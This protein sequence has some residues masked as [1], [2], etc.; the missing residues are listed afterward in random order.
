MA[1]YSADSNQEEVITAD[2]TD[3]SRTGF[4]LSDIGLANRVEETRQASISYEETVT[5]D[6][7]NI[8]SRDGRTFLDESPTPWPI[9]SRGTGIANQTRVTRPGATT[10]FK[11]AV[12]AGYVPTS[13]FTRIEGTVRDTAG[14]IIPDAKWIVFPGPLDIAGSIS[15]NGRFS[16]NLLKQEYGPAFIIVETSD[17][18]FDFR[19]FNDPKVVF[20]V[21]QQ[22]G[23]DLDL[24]FKPGEP[25]VEGGGLFVG[26][27][28]VVGG[29]G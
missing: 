15:S 29:F 20:S 24:Q 3:T 1:T 21:P 8:D 13:D 6:A 5:L 19:W 25:T 27:G 10:D 23:S 14:N 9:E 12:R 2:S 4:S 7:V 17:A 26:K 18:D 28:V 16:V 11:K 22:A